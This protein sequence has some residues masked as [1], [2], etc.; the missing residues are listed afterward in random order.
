MA[1]FNN[2]INI[3]PTYI[4]TGISPFRMPCWSSLSIPI[5]NCF[6]NIN[7]FPNFTNFN[8][9]GST[10][11]PFLAAHFKQPLSIFPLHYSIYRASFKPIYGA[12][13]I[14]Q[15]LGVIFL[16]QNLIGV[17]IFTLQI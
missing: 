9:F 14:I 6:N 17:R 16:T 7:I 11:I 10:Q 15:I 3:N 5:F 4:N 13:Q 1:I 12:N 2:F 8:F